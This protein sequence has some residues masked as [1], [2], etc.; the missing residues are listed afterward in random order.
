MTVPITKIYES[1]FPEIQNLKEGDLSE[2]NTIYKEERYD[3]F[4]L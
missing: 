2:I 4:A 1:V 3:C